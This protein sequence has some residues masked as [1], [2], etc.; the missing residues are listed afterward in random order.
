[1][2]CSILLCSFDYNYQFIKLKPRKVAVKISLTLEVF[3][4]DFD[5]FKK[6]I[7]SAELQLALARVT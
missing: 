3:F 2:Q 4:I 1:M 7:N 6:L 5:F